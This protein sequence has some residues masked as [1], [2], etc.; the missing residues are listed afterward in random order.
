M[1]PCALTQRIRKTPTPHCGSDLR[2]GSHRFRERFSA[3]LHQPP[4]LYR[5]IF[6][7]LFVTAFTIYR[8]IL[9]PSM[10]RLSRI[11]SNIF[12]IL[13]PHSSIRRLGS[14]RCTTARYHESAPLSHLFRRLCHAAATIAE[15]RRFSDSDPAIQ[16]TRLA[17]TPYN[18]R[19]LYDP[20]RKKNA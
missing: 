13:R 8:Y 20:P 9:Y 17:Q 19:R 14:M 1:K 5:R 16:L 6:P 7:T 12:V 4:V 2:L 10:R 3:D 15:Y 18:T 11:F